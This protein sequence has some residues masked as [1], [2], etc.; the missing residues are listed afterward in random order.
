MI[1]NGI[2]VDE[3]AGFVELLRTTPAAGVASLRSE[4]RWRDGYR[5]DWRAEQVTLADQRIARR[6]TLRLDLPTELGGADY[7]PAPGELV[8]AA[9]GACV[10]HQFVEHAAQRGVVLD[11]LE[12]T[13]ESHLD[14]RGAYQVADVRPGW[15]EARIQLSVRTEASD[16]VLAELLRDA[17]RTSPVL[18][19][20]AHPVPMQ[21]SV[22][23]LS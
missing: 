7:G 1:R 11:A 19:T 13:C 5:L 6:H 3:V 14:L 4:H 18:D 17:V 10:A 15:S 9:L 20:V 22:R 8:A 12:V 21:P 23:R 2:E 16:E